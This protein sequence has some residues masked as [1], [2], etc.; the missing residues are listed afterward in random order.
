MRLSWLPGLLLA[1]SGMSAAQA[2]PVHRYQVEVHES[3]DR[4]RVRACFDGPAPSALA[5]ETSG[6][7]AFLE[8]VK[9]TGSGPARLPDGDGIV[10]EGLADDSCIEY[11]VKLEAAREGVQTGGP[12]SRWAGRDLLSSIGDWLWRPP[13]EAG[14]IEITFK[15]PSGVNVSTPWQRSAGNGG[16]H[17]YRVGPTPANWPGIVAFGR[18]TE[19]HVAVDGGTLHLAILDG[20]PPQQQAWIERWIAAA[21]RN[22]STL[23]GRFPMESVQVIVAPTPRGRGPV[24]WAYVS[25]GG[26]PAVHLFINPAHP[27]EA[28]ARDWSATHEMSHLFLPYVVARDVWLMEGLP[29]Y[30]QNVLMARGGAIDEREAWKRMIV[31]FQRAAKVGAGLSLAKASERVGTAGLYQRVYWAGAALMLEADLRL[32]EQSGGTQSLD[33]ALGAIAQ[34][35]FGQ[36]RRWTA[37]ELMEQL[38]KTTG[39][40]IFGDI[41]REQLDDI[42]FPD[43]KAVLVRAG[44]TV[45]DGEVVLDDSAPWAAARQALMR[46]S[47]K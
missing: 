31:G 9:V 35:C 32:R 13:R 47:D 18:F 33:T 40:P 12:E 2:A 38:D 46:P 21:A 11:R 43:F 42:E 36:E 3:L 27:A 41:V 17:V 7:R 37:A 29:T 4:L 34:C 23:Q 16:A 10:L 45:A 26:G 19:R 1:A 5:A 14:E 8:Q 6:A 20:P 25:R 15:L 24:P 39:T 30:L 44:V 22:A 28:F